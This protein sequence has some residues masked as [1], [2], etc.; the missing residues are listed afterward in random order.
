MSLGAYET[1]FVMLWCLLLARSITVN[2]VQ[3]CYKSQQQ[4]RWPFRLRCAGFTRELLGDDTMF[5][6]ALF[7]QLF[8]LSP[9]LC[10][11]GRVKSCAAPEPWETIAAPTVMQKVLRHTVEGV[12]QVY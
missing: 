11:V 4:V 3:F 12:W 1:C 2:A 7:C 6:E 5:V 10:R 8:H 9:F